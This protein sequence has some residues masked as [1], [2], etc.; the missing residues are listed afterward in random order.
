MEG[1]FEIGGWDG[2]PAQNLYMPF[3]KLFLSLLLSGSCQ[4][5]A[6]G[7]G[8]TQRQKASM[9]PALSQSAFYSMDHACVQ[10]DASRLPGAMQA[11]CH[12]GFWDQMVR[13]VRT[14]DPVLACEEESQGAQ[15]AAQ[16]F[17]LCTRIIMAST[18][19][20]TAAADLHY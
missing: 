10:P 2:S 8:A 14:G 9:M 18:S 16:T 17:R 11:F 15:C 1:D 13:W 6:T 7:T 3:S 5:S 19:A 4:W 20:Q 12:S